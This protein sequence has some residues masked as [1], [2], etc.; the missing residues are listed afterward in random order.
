MLN[1]DLLDSY[2]DWLDGKEDESL[3]EEV[4]NLR[5]KLASEDETVVKDA[6]LSEAM[7]RFHNNISF[8]TFVEES[9]AKSANFKFYVGYLDAV[10][11]LLHYVRVSRDYASFKLDKYIGAME[12]LIP[13]INAGDRMLY[14]RILD[15][16][17][18]Q[19]KRLQR[20][21]PD[22]AAEL[23]RGTGL[24]IRRNG[25]KFGGIWPDLCHEQGINKAAA[26]G[27]WRT[28]TDVNARNV[29]FR[30]YTAIRYYAR[31]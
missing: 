8:T 5:F 26:F 31:L 23:E 6:L 17:C 2:L 21:H 18:E 29:F 24:V 14:R 25:E 4:N 12:S 10:A 30:A 28:T 22:I 27:L 15:I 1:E 9:S 7:D 19:L 3:R 20:S 11:D 13:I 16:H